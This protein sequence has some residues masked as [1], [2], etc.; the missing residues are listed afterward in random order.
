MNNPCFHLL[1]D[2][3]IINQ[4]FLLGIPHG[5]TQKFPT[6]V[7]GPMRRS[8]WITIEFPMK[9][10]LRLR[11]KWANEWDII[12]INIYIY[13]HNGVLFMNWMVYYL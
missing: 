11:K 1:I 13:T 12:Y 6:E 4:P 7:T 3:P 10:I 2:F 8:K 9:A 5:N